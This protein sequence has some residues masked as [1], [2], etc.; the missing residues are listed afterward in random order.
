M[1][2][3]FNCLAAFASPIKVRT[4]RLLLTAAALIKRS[5][6]FRARSRPPGVVSPRP[7]PPR[8]PR[9]PSLPTPPRCIPPFVG[10][11]PRL[12][13]AGREL[14][15]GGGFSA[16]R[17]CGGA[18]GGDAQYECLALIASCVRGLAGSSLA[19]AKGRH[20]TSRLHLVPFAPSQSLRLAAGWV[21]LVLVL[22]SLLTEPAM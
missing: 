4:G 6:R 3:D 17:G 7:R 13:G 15:A 5:A 8:P 22:A 16:G 1:D 14:G 18:D 19:V 2:S 20:S 10:S 11:T 9:P 21:R 12:R